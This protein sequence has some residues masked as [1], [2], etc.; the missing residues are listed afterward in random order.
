MYVIRFN[1]IFQC[2]WM[3]FRRLSAISMQI[4]SNLMYVTCMYVIFCI[5]SLCIWRCIF[6]NFCICLYV[7][8]I[9]CFK[10]HPQLPPPPQI[11]LVVDK[12]H[13]MNVLR[14]PLVRIR[15]KCTFFSPTNYSFS[16]FALSWFRDSQKRTHTLTHIV[17]CLGW[18]RHLY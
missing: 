14:R 10:S 8:L 2:T 13:L 3:N 12:P 7:F 6:A 5:Y 9:I 15:R 1:S 18:P 16:Y 17:L 11:E 4:W